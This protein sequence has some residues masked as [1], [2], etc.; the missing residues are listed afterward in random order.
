VCVV[1]NFSIDLIVQLLGQRS[2]FDLYH[3]LVLQDR[4]QFGFKPTGYNRHN[5]MGDFT[6][7]DFF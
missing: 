3:L 1:Q 6:A 2:L 7:P 5:N 4:M